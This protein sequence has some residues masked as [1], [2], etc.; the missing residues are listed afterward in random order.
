M[1]TQQN[2]NPAVQEETAIGS[3]IYKYLSYWPLFLILT[4]I[5]LTGAYLYLWYATPLY[6]ARASL[7]IK[8]QKKGSDDTKF[9]EQLDLINTN[10]IID[11][12]I[13]VI[14]S[15]ILMA[16]VVRAL[17][18]Y[19][20][21]YQQGKFKSTSA[22]LT[23]PVLV[24]AAAPDS[25]KEI[26][27]VY[28]QYDSAS[29][30]VLLDNKYKYQLNKWL[31]TPY[32][33]LRFV[34]N[35]KYYNNYQNKPF[36]F[37]LIQPRNAALGLLGNLEVYP[38]S[39]ASSIIDL[40]YTDEVP[41]RA[42]DILN[43]LLINYT[44]AGLEEKS[45]LAKNTLSFVEGRLAVVS[46]KLDSIERQIQQYKSGTGAI[47]LSSQGEMF[48]QNVSSNDQKLSD[49][50]NQLVVL[51]EV[52]KFVKN[53]D[54]NAGIVPSTVGVSDP[55]LTQL[56]NNL[57]SAQLEYEKLKKTVAENNP[58]LVSVSDQINKIKPDI[59]NNIQSLGYQ[60]RDLYIR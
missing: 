33:T 43:N 39:K 29:A 20:P 21:I 16:K 2:I 58:L 45:K 47:N 56:V 30:T 4:I 60:N 13:E 25:L 5:C 22:Y 54:N 41:T 14:K 18:L 8:D 27:Q 28:L 11:N 15:R 52:E 44:Q 34:N 12:E 9:M 55:V 31:A 17:N 50:S 53:K 37:A 19:A 36:Y 51:N 3:V 23:S 26:A 7:V 48:L 32:G 42:E 49:V 40:N 59:L 38:S 6:Q 46:N 10:K 35:P 1:E 57:Y 24:Q